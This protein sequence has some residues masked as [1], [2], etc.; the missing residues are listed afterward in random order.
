VEK[1]AH[2]CSTSNSSAKYCIISYVKGR[3]L[4]LWLDL[5]GGRLGPPR[6]LWLAQPRS[7]PPRRKYATTTVQIKPSTRRA[8]E[9]TRRSAQTKR[10]RPR[11]S[12]S[13][14]R[15]MGLFARE[16]HD[17]IFQEGILPCT[18]ISFMFSQKYGIC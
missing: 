8:A 7:V 17:M 13:F 4:S 10:Q 15:A 11:F 1:T 9:W 18:L 3:W 5:R 6:R 16:N 2:S 14:G 12:L